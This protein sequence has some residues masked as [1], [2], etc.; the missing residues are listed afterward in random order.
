LILILIGYMAA[1]FILSSIPDTGDIGQ[2]TAFV[3][4][5]IQNMLH[6]PIY[7]F[8]ALLWIFTLRTRGFPENR[9]VWLAILLSSAYGGLLE[10]YQIWVPG[11][12][13]SFLD[14]FVNVSGVLLFVWVYQ[15]MKMGAGGREQGAVSS[16]Q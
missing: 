3:S 15:Q 1:I 11:R 7:G 4:P 6:F 14:F 9:S 16:K 13:P 10:I 12:F 2:I 8:L 5:T